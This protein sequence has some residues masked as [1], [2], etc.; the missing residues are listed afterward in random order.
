MRKDKKAA[1][2]LRK[3]GKTYREIVEELGISK[4]TLSEWFRDVPWSRHITTRNAAGNMTPQR[5]AGMQRK[6]KEKLI[7]LY[8][9]SEADA[10]IQYD[11]LKNEPLFWAGLM[12]YAGEGDKRTRHLIRISNSEF[13]IHNIFLMFLE[14][15]LG[16][17]K[18]QVKCALIIYPEHNESLCKEMWSNALKI[19]REN[20][21]KTQ[22]IKGKEQ[23]KRL[24]YGVGMSIISNTALKKKLLKWLALAEDEQFKS[25]HSLVVE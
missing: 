5:I 19:H 4:S 7:E 14:R 1:F 24:Q 13:Y 21:Y 6:R 3:E 22:I 2:E 18:Q 23:K 25:D 8:A 16:Y 9:D 10:V 11:T 15:Y 12:I 20:F 17:A